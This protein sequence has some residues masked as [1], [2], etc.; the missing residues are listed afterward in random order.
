MAQGHVS[1]Q[2]TLVRGHMGTQGMMARR[3]RRERD[4]ADSFWKN[5]SFTCR[6]SQKSIFYIIFIRCLGLRIIRRSDYGLG[7][8]FSFT[9]IFQR[10]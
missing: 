10:Y 2:G 6:T 7:Y 3:A 8:E 1:T 9:D 4:L 5:G